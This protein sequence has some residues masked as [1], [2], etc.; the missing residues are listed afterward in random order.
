M[1]KP[2]WLWCSTPQVTPSEVDRLWQAFL[3][4]FDNLRP[5]TTLPASAPKLHGP[6][7]GRP[8]GSNN[9]HRAPRYDP[10]KNTKTDTTG[11]NQKAQTG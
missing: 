9:A 4:R 6:G 10:G 5:T 8:P 7:P 2:V 11:N 3:R 1:P